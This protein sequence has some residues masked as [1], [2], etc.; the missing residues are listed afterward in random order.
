MIGI[1]A[2]GSGRDTGDFAAKLIAS[3]RVSI[4]EYTTHERSG[5]DSFEDIVD[6]TTSKFKYG[7]KGPT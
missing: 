6:I 5:L 3:D 1:A 7:V 4:S 2:T